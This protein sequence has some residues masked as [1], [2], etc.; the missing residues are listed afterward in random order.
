MNR[1]RFFGMSIAALTAIGLPAWL[2][3]ER[4][5]FLPPVCGWYPSD[6]RMRETIQYSAID[7]KL[8]IRHDALFRN[9]TLGCLTSLEQVQVVHHLPNDAENEQALW[10]EYSLATRNFSQYE[11]GS[12]VNVR[13]NPDEIERMRHMSRL[14]LKQFSDLQG[15]ESYRGGRLPLLNDAFA[16]YV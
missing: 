14:R 4:S 5:I 11:N 12:S 6:L 2:L 9:G 8:F 7:D 13:F 10:A 15:L 3:P 1:R 16:R